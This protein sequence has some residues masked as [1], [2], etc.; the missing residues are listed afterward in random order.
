MTRTH[1]AG[2]APAS[3]MPT[4]T[5]PP[6]SMR[7]ATARAPRQRPTCIRI[8][9]DRL[10]DIDRI[11]QIQARRIHCAATTHMV[12]APLCRRLPR[13]WPHLLREAPIG[14]Q[15]QKE[16]I[17]RREDIVRLHRRRRASV[18]REGGC[19]SFEFEVF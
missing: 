2:P 1:I 18:G 15:W 12:P 9:A 10:E 19:V 4:I 3:A 6:T 11:Q 8:P 5:I 7:I 16:K 14:A 17:S 13:L